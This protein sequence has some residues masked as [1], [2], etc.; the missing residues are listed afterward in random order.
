MP[1][2]EVRQKLIAAATRSEVLLDESPRKKAATATE[3]A[4]KRFIRGSMSAVDVEELAATEACSHLAPKSAE[5][6]GSNHARD[7]L[8]KLK[9]CA[10]HK[11]E[12]YAC[13]VRLWDCKAPVPIEEDMHFLLPYEFVESD[14]GAAEEWADL[15]SDPAVHATREEWATRMGVD[16]CGLVATGI[17]GDTAPFWA[18]DSLMRLLWSPLGGP[19]SA[20]AGLSRRRRHWICAVAKRMMCD[21]GCNGRHTM[22]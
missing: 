2:R 4:T 15:G 11:P 19:V 18:R 20:K 7:L 13:L 10:K 3:F 9:K 1:R 12:V 6:K 21:C 22:E 17:W 14:E 5:R 16:T 8:R